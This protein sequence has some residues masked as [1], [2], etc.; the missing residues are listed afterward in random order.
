MVK[1]VHISLQS[2]WYLKLLTKRKNVPQ[3]SIDPDCYANLTFQHLTDIIFKSQDWTIWK[4][5]LIIYF[6]WWN[7]FFFWGGGAYLKL[8]PFLHSMHCKQTHKYFTYLKTCCWLEL[9]NLI[10]KI[11]L[12]KYFTNI[13]MLWHINLNGH[14]TLHDS[15]WLFAQNLHNI[16]IVSCFSMSAGLN[17]WKLKQTTIFLSRRYRCQT[18]L[19]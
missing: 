16:W 12:R 10:K 2:T 9:K 1:R 5:Q 7:M 8:M 4:M 17:R 19:P 11:N 6:R 15:T 14:N 18:P 3:C 13:W